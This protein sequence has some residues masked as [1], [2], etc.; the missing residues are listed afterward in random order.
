[1]GPG[2]DD[3]V[4]A[5]QEA[6]PHRLPGHTALLTLRYTCKMRC[7]ISHILESHRGFL[8]ESFRLLLNLKNSQKDS[9]S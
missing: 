2:G 7:E 4:V 3:Q 9:K 8:N 1:M 5:E 6:L